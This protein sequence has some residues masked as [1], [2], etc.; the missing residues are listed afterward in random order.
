MK[1][2]PRQIGVGG[3]VISDYEKQLVNEVLESSQLTYGPMTKRFEQEFARRHGCAFGLFMNSGTSALHVALAALKEH[4]QWADGDEVIVPAITFVATCNIVL[5]NGMTPVFVDVEPDTYNMDPAKIEERI[6]PKTRAIIPVHLLGLPA[7]MDPILKIARKY[8]M[9]VLEDSCE[10]MFAKYKDS[11]VGSMGRIGCFSTYVAHFLVTGVG[12]LAITNDPALAVAM[13]SL[14]NHGRDNIYIGCKDDEGAEGS[15][16]EEIVEK[17]FHFIHLG[18]SFRCT[19]MEAALGVGQLARA[20]QNVARR[21]EIGE[22]FN[23][24]LAVYADEL[25]LPVCPPDRTHSYMLY[26]LVLRHENKKRL[27]HFLEGLNIETRDLLPLINQPVYRR[28]FGNL[29]NQYPVASKLNDSGFYIGCHYYLSDE[30]V[31][32]VA[33]A[34]H[35]F[36]ATQYKSQAASRSFAPAAL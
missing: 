25:Q 22:Y 23:R 13:R 26:G 16:L 27:V 9:Q 18:H 34:F 19:E 33:G 5:H 10:T 29:E 20:D 31:E 1:K 24:E 32:Y 6:T 28:L 11:M 2:F 17:R 12:G 14:M 36:F 15:R 4:H 35:E 3:L 21:K 8:G 7:A 30:E